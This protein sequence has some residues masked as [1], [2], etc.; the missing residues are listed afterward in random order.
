MCLLLLLIFIIPPSIQTDE[1]KLLAHLLKGNSP[2]ARPVF[3]TKKSVNVTFGYEMVH[4]V[5]IVETEQMITGKVWIRM[6]WTNEYMTW[7]PSKWGGVTVTRM[8]QSKV[9][10]PDIFMQEDVSGDMASG[11]ERYRT[12]VKMFSNGLHSWM[13][14]ALLHASCSFD[15]Y[16]FPFDKQRCMMIFTPWTHDMSEVNMTISKVSRV[17]I[18][19]IQTYYVIL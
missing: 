14:P 11:P 19:F 12:L 4:I 8:D 6:S 7:D 2:F 10:T 1:R 13:V 5:R 3:D 9:W 17:K 15:V 18:A 16:N